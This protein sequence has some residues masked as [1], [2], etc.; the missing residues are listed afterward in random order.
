ME[1]VEEKLRCNLREGKRRGTPKTKME[2]WAEKWRNSKPQNFHDPMMN[3]IA[4]MAL[5]CKL[6]RETWD[7]ESCVCYNYK[8]DECSIM[9]LD[10]E[11]SK[12]VDV[13]YSLPFPE[14]EDDDE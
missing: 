3:A 4:Q 8:T 11:P 13:T 7:C 9:N 10:E 14:D 6:T 1:Y 5:V 12:W 2:G